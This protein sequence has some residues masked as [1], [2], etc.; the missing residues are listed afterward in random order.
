MCLKQDNGNQLPNEIRRGVSFIHELSFSATRWNRRDTSVW[1]HFLA[2]KMF[3]EVALTRN[4]IYWWKKSTNKLTLFQITKTADKFSR[5]GH[6]KV[7]TF[8]W[9]NGRVEKTKLNFLQW[10]YRLCARAKKNVQNWLTE[11]SLIIY[12]LFKPFLILPFIC[13]KSLGIYF[14]L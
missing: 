8:I 14:S 13:S 1:C 11:L 7:H 2:W 4:R 10:P 6:V 9:F 3:R 12:P 5:V